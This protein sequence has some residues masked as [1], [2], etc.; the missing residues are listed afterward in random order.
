MNRDFHDVFVSRELWKDRFIFRERWSR[1]P[2]YHP[3]SWGTP[4]KRVSSWVRPVKGRGER[5][6]LLVAPRLIFIETRNGKEEP[7]NC[8]ASL[9]LNLEHCN[10]KANRQFQVLEHSWFVGW[11]LWGFGTEGREPFSAKIIWDLEQ[12]GGEGGNIKK[13]HLTLIRQEILLISIH[14]RCL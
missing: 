2:L 4:C 7:R 10:S 6:T 3:L 9:Q 13:H 12:G 1:P 14:F 11:G 5:W 8:A